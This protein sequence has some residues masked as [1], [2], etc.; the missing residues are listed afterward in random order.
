[1]RKS[2]GATLSNSPDAIRLRKK[3]GT[4][5]S[6]QALQKGAAV[7]RD[8]QRQQMAADDGPG[9]CCGRCRT[10]TGIC[11]DKQCFKCHGR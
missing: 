1:M 6:F 10:P 11:A 5:T 7:D 9:R 3:R 2:Y 8:Y 4:G